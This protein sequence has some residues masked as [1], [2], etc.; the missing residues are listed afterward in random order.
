MHFVHLT[1]TCA[2]TSLN[3]GSELD[4]LAAMPKRQAILSRAASGEEINAHN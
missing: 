1:I 4:A 3:K 2:G